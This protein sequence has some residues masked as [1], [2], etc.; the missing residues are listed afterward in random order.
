[1][2]AIRSFFMLL[3]TLALLGAATLAAALPVSRLPVQTIGHDASQYA[4]SDNRG[5]VM[6]LVKAH[7]GLWSSANPDQYPYNQFVTEDF[8]L[9]YPYQKEGKL[10]VEG[11]EAAQR[12]LTDFARAGTGWKFSDITL[13]ETMYSDVFFVEFRSSAFIPATNQTYEGSH[14]A[15]VTLRDGKIAGIY[16]IWDRDARTQAFDGAGELACLTR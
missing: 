11:A 10:R 14:M 7:L 13:Y 8:V 16:E 15:R 4:V 12:A 6:S 1:M 9:V 5:E 3:S 2:L